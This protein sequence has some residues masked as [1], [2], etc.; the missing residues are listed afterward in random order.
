MWSDWVTAASLPVRLA[1][2][3][4]DLPDPLPAL[5]VLHGDDLRLRPVEVVGDEGYLLVELVEGVA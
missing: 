3:R 4:R 1:I 5:G 2:D